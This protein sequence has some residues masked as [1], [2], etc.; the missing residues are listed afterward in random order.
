MKR[1]FYLY[2]CGTVCAVILF[3]VFFYA[4]SADRRNRRFLSA[5][6]W[7]VE[8]GR[9]ECAAVKIPKPL[10]EVYEQYNKIQDM[11]GLDLRPYEGEEGVRYTYIVTNFPY[12]TGEGVRANVLCIGGEPVGGDIMTVSATGFMVDL[13]YLERKCGESRHNGQYAQKNSEIGFVIH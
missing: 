7:E 10:G 9:E 3:V 2:I 11:A 5:Y 1:S 6:G 12:E 13:S 4:G 8:R